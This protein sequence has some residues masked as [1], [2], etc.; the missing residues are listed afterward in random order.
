M[1]L[2]HKLFIGFG[3]AAFISLII[4]VV[5]LF[6]IIK[7]TET[8]K[9]VLTSDVPSLK[10][11]HELKI[12]GLNHRR[13]EKD[14]FL[15]IGNQE[16]M[17][18]CKGK[19]DKKSESLLEKLK[20]IE[21]LLKKDEHAPK[22]SLSVAA[23]AL[24]YYTKY[25]KGFENVTEATLKDPSITPQ[26]ANKL[27]MPFKDH[28]Y[29][30]E[31]SLDEIIKITETMM[32]ESSKTADK[33]GHSSRNLILTFLVTG[34]LACII[35][36]IL[37]S[38]NIKKGLNALTGQINEVSKGNIKPV[39]GTS[40]KDEISLVRIEFNEF[41]NKLRSL[42]Q[43][44]I[45][46]SCSLN[47][48]SVKLSDVSKLVVNGS[49]EIHAA[50]RALIGSADA[51][52]T[53]MSTISAA[54]D[55]S[56]SN[57]G[58][59]ASASGE[60]ASTVN[61]ISKNSENARTITE[62]AVKQVS[63]ASADIEKL[64]LAANQITKVTEAISD[65]SEQTNLLAL[66][67]TIEAARA[68]ESGKGFAVV[69]NE[70]KELARQTSEATLDI[71]KQVE[72]IQIST[73][74]AVKV[75]KTISEVIVEINDIVSTIAASVHEQSAT[76]GEIA[77]SISHVS[78]GINEV[79]EKLADNSAASGEVTKKIGDISVATN[80][81][82]ANSTTIEQNSVELGILSKKLSD[83]V[84]WFSID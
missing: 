9:R 70:I 69:A 3:G 65:I 8:I 49:E 54:M 56:T 5:G 47:E 43:D 75:I 34:V 77:S 33:L 10:I 1:K 23:K 37:I 11:A 81:I 55:Q 38:Q 39:S 41:I 44:I 29:I 26:Q 4:G 61:E 84:A 76:T 72:G 22:D 20:Q 82:K 62:K 36:G 32:G 68:G 19:F 79:N 2:T 15:N 13:F 80:N 71:K 60:M 27:M 12:E 25:R 17:K 24:D 30:F 51:M 59:I 31:S 58:V 46:N 83:M 16:K 64:G 18:E 78:D 52:N 73:D 74:T 6:A 50:T 40:G 53:N 45:N 21:N 63:V 48:S 7:E 14:F 67:A 35:C 57:A 42:I 66:N 28:I